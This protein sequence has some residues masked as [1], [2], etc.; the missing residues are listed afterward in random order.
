MD[1]ISNL[2]KKYDL[3]LLLN[4]K[5]KTSADKELKEV[6]EEF[7]SLFLNEMLKRANAAKLAES[8]LSND[9]QETYMSLLNQ[10]RAKLIAKSQSFGIAEALV[11]QFSRR[12]NIS[13]NA[14]KK[15]SID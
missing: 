15:I 9:E 6:A 8:I 5:V 1:G 12:K 11:N 13:P 3:N 10:E 2:T 7:E 4:E 14:S